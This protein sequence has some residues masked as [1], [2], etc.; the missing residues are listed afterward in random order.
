MVGVD[1]VGEHVG[2]HVEDGAAGNGVLTAEDRLDRGPLCLAGFLV[3]D[4]ESLATALV[5]GAG[6]ANSPAKLTPAR[7]VSPEAAALDQVADAGAAMT[8][9]RQSVELARAA[10]CAVA[11]DTSRAWSCQGVMSVIRGSSDGDEGVFTVTTERSM[12]CWCSQGCVGSSHHP[13][14]PKRSRAS[15]DTANGFAPG[16]ECRKDG[17][18]TTRPRQRRRVQQEVWLMPSFKALL[19]GA[20]RV[21]AR[22]RPGRRVRGMEGRRHGPAQAGQ[23]L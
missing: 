1:H 7:S 10:E 3:D 4:Q 12:V 15:S 18:M 13:R 19:A 22:G 9:R 17:G 16:A 14:L 2:E 8:F 11:G 5:N 23:G 6:H 20:Q 21:L